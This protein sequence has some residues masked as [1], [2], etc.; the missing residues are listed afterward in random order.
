MYTKTVTY[1]DF[2][3]NEI[4]EDLWFFI[5]KAE[6]V[7]LQSS[8]R[9]GYDKKIKKMVETKNTK[10]LLEFIKELVLSSYGKKSEDGTRFIKKNPDG[11]KLR[12]EFEESIAF[13]TFFMELINSPDMLSEFMYGVLPS[14]LAAKAKS[15]LANQLPTL[16]RA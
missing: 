5:N 9:D 1:T 15:E 6:L 11:T 3:G 2:N 8:R 10:E 12:D 16:T 4:S 13:D 14:D 7:K